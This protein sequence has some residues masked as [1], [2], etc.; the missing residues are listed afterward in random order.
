[1]KA[2]KI[3]T[4]LFL[5]TMFWKREGSILVIFGCSAEERHPNFDCVC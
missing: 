1:M 4:S 2:K 3:R 5:V